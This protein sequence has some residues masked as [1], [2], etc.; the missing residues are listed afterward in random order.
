M[1]QYKVDGITIHR[2]VYKHLES[3]MFVLI[4]DDEAFVVDAHVNSKI[5]DFLKANSVAKITIGLTHEHFDH[6]CGVVGLKDNFNST[7][8]CSKSCSDSV[9]VAA[10][11]RPLLISALIIENDRKNGTSFEQE[12]LDTHQPFTFF[13]DVLFEDHYEGQWRG[14]KIAFK[15]IPGHSRG[16]ACIFIDDKILFTGD[17]LLLNLD[18]ITR[19]PGGS[20]KDYNEKTLPY[21]KSLD[22]N[23]FVFPGHEEPF[24]LRDKF[25]SDITT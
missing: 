21:L 17:S 16:S 2:F 25:S 24:Y 14:H 18:T 19:F 9:S 5:I 3:N 7:I 15:S 23:L 8:I 13:G 20:T 12:F 4:E 22:R 6:T 11:N 10:K 1:N